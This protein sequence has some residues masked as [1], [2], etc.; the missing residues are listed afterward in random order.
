MEVQ[1]CSYSLTTL[2]LNYALLVSP[3]ILTSLILDFPQE[4]SESIVDSVH[5]P[6]GREHGH[7]DYELS[8]KRH[9]FV[10]GIE[11]LETR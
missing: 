3:R 9:S 10:G 6:L 11:P 8:V 7:V 1:S 4:I 5:H 2:S